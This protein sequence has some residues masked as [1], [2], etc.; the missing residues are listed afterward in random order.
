MSWLGEEPPRGVITEDGRPYLLPP[1]TKPMK[2]GVCGDLRAFIIWI[3]LGPLL[4]HVN[5]V[6]FCGVMCANTLRSIFPSWEA[7][8]S[9]G[10]PYP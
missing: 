5:P 7:H 8:P 1:G 3:P 2:C 10:R 6:P 9:T 4:G